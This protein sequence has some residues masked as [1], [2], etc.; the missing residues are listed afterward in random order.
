[1]AVRKGMGFLD[2]PKEAA[3]DPNAAEAREA[4]RKVRAGEGVGKAAETVTDSKGRAREGEAGR[5]G[6]QSKQGRR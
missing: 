2:N 3:P 4:I 1:M 6:G 5:K